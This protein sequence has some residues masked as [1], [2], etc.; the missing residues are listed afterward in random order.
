MTYVLLEY[1]AANVFCNIE[2]YFGNFIKIGALGLRPTR[3]RHSWDIR[4]CQM[5]LNSLNWYYLEQFYNLHTCMP[6]SCITYRT[7]NMFLG[8]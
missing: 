6:W 3:L 7:V 5:R 2:T 4:H 1:E 8:L